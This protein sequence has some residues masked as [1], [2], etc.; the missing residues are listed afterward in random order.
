MLSLNLLSKSDLPLV[1]KM[2]H[3]I[4]PIHY[5]PIIGV[6]QVEYMLN[7]MYS[8]PVLEQKFNEGHQFYLIKEGDKS[9]G[10]ISTSSPDNRNFFLHKFYILPTQQGKKL[11]EQIFN[12]LYRKLYHAE[13]IRLYVNRQNYKSINFYFKLGFKIEK[14]NELDIGE[15]YFMS[16]FIML[17]KAK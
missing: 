4:W 5:T 12:Q 8:V 17:W 3:E 9:I 11:G 2:A 16:D 14:L 13:S 1:E 6:K 10:Y 15:G 7:K